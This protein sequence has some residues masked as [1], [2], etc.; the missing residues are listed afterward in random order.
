MSDSDSLAAV[1]ALLDCSHLAGPDSLPELVTRAGA[2][3][4]ADSV[5]LFLVDYDQTVLVPL[6][7][8]V[9]GAAGSAHVELSVESTLA[10][11]AFTDVA[12]Q[13]SS[14]G[15]GSTVWTPVLDG[16]IASG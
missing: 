12:Q 11:R 5:E 10:G 1:R 7:A 15:D 2:L 14:V 13:V 3:I 6:A 9:A 8:H 16:T 4:G